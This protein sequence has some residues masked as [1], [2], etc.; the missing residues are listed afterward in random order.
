MED[1]KS[2]KIA[3]I[4]AV[5]FFI[6]L[7]S[8]FSAWKSALPQ[9]ADSGRRETVR[10]TAT[11]YPLYIMLLNI[12]DGADG[13]ELS[14]LAPAGTGCLHDYQL[15]AGDMK[16]IERCDILVANGSGMEDFI[17]KALELKKD[18]AI[19]SSEGFPLAEGNPHVWVSPAG[20]LYEV[21]KIAEGL[22]RL[23][24]E[25]AGQYKK[26][27]AEYSS[28]LESLQKKMHGELDA[29]SGEAIIPFHEAFP[30]FAQEFGFFIPAVIE[31][32]PGSAPSPKELNQT[33]ET[34][35]SAL[36]SGRS[37]TLFAEPQYSSAAADIISR[38]TG[39]AVHELDP[40]VTGKLEKDAYITCMERNASV[41]K[42]AFLQAAP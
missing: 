34:V 40:A 23:D 36:E 5:S 16:A 35:K 1:K 22:C 17:E 37:V 15:T 6:L 26:N 11:F 25:N 42:N 2:V 19:I 24:P 20:A 10:I 28:R 27:A 12:T 32:E 8:V 4:A 29:F 30:Y 3:V 39:L 13:A 41:L 38:E 9:R 18:A 7:I 21:K 33:I 14:L 31:R